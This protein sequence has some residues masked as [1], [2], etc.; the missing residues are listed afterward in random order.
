[1]VPPVRTRIVGAGLIPA[2]LNCPGN[3]WPGD[4]AV[5]VS[6]RSTT[7][8]SRGCP[9]HS[10]GRQVHASHHVSAANVDGSVMPA[11]DGGVAGRNGGG[12]TGGVCCCGCCARRPA[13][14][15]PNAAVTLAAPTC[16][17]LRRVRCVG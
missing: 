10:A 3:T 13:A 16:S 11:A 14:D 12:A 5:V 7:L 4:G 9:G 8:R 17:I 2:K 15:V 6:L 1:M